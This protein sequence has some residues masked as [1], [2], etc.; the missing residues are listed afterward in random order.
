MTN[1][2]DCDASLQRRQDDGDLG[3]SDWVERRR[4]LVEH[5]DCWPPVKCASDRQQLLLASRQASARFLEHGIDAVTK[6]IDDRVE[7]SRADRPPNGIFVNCDVRLA[8]SD[9]AANGVRQQ[10]RF[11]RHIAHCPLPRRKARMQVHAIDQDAPV[12]WSQ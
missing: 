7:T 12:C 9:V 6:S 5:Q 3:S 2:H 1:G 11:L 8:K 10:K 4:R